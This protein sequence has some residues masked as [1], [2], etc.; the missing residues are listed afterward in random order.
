M[1]NNTRRWIIS[2]RWR[3]EGQRT[4][5]K[6][7]IAIDE[8]TCNLGDARVVRCVSLIPTHSLRINFESNIQRQ[9]ILAPSRRNV[10][11]ASR[12]EWISR[13]KWSILICSSAFVLCCGADALR[14][15][16]RLQCENGKMETENSMNMYWNNF[17]ICSIRFIV[18]IV[19]ACPGVRVFQF[20]LYATDEKDKD[21]QNRTEVNGYS[22]HSKSIRVIFSSVDIE[23]LRNGDVGRHNVNLFRDSSSSF[24]A[25]IRHG[26]GNTATES[27]NGRWAQC[28]WSTRE[29]IVMHSSSENCCRSRKRYKMYWMS[30]S[31]LAMAWVYLFKAQ[32][33]QRPPM[34]MMSAKKTDR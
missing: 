17:T 6:R 7:N 20:T 33:I 24:T 19:D 2:S 21:R 18:R 10:F 28:A 5:M 13:I 32:G 3:W 16:C 29:R 9:P 1:A 8:I 15:R 22:I 27:I 31:S 26:F 23:P 11:F 25:A 30:R 34:R 12:I 4:E 14:I